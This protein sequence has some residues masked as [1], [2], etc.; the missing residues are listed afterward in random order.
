MTG[1]LAL[2]RPASSSVAVSRCL[3]RFGDAASINPYDTFTLFVELHFIFAETDACPADFHSAT[4]SI[5]RVAPTVFCFDAYA[6]LLFGIGIRRCD[7]HEPDG[8][9]AMTGSSGKV[10]IGMKSPDPLVSTSIQK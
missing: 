7:D 6:K 5:R 4:I 1:L 10:L 8:I 3:A 9:A 2:L